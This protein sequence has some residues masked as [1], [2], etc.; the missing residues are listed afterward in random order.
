MNFFLY[1]NRKL[2]LF[3]GTVIILFFILIIFSKQINLMK[4]DLQNVE[5]KLS[6]ADI[7][8]PRFAINNDSK[9]IFVTAKEGNF[10]NNDK[11]LLKENVRFQSNDFSI[12]TEKVIFDRNNQTAHSKS[13]SLFK[14]KNTTISSDGFNIYD[15]GNKIIFHG[16]SF[17]VLK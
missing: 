12:E 2:I 5:L 7:S 15:R 4:I 10:L 3:V 11:I 1:I 13:K 6:K 14:S 16:K 8:E 9:K 17:V